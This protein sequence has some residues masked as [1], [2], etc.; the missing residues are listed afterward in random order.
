MYAYF[1]RHGESEANVLKVF[2]NERGAY[3]LTEKGRS[4]AEALADTLTSVG[5]T[6]MYASPLLRAQQTAQI[7]ADRL[8]LTFET[9]NALRE[10]SVGDREGC[11]HCSWDDY[12]QIEIEW[13]IGKNDEARIG[14]GECLEDIEQRFM[15]LIH[16]IVAKY[17]S[18]EEKILLIGHGGVLTCM[19]PILCANVDDQ[20][21]IDHPLRPASLIVT[22]Y[23]EERFTCLNWVDT[24]L[25]PL[26]LDSSQLAS[27]VAS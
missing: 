1:A 12:R 15:P 4:Q 20:F 22:R 3:G 25:A 16:D 7:V 18:S 5:I 8:K 17:G 2:A 26:P 19:I 23:L 24:Q 9:T 10:F 11:D 21:A 27:Q 14:G 6:R 13:L